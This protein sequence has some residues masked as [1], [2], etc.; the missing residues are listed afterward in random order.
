MADVY[1]RPLAQEVGGM[2]VSLDPALIAALKQV[3]GVTGASTYRAR[4][5]IVDGRRVAVA[6]IDAGFVSHYLKLE[7]LDAKPEE[8][9]PPTAAGDA[10]L[11]SEPFARRFHR[12]R[13]DTVSLVTPDGQRDFAIAGV[14]YDYTADRGVIMMDRAHFAHWWHDDTINSIALYTGPGVDATQVVET[15][16]HDY[17]GP[18]GLYVASNQ[19]LRDEILTIFDRT[20]SVTDIMQGLAAL[21]AFVGVLSALLA[22]LL[23]RTRE[24]GTLRAIGTTWQGLVKLIA[25][26]TAFMGLVAS[27]LAMGCG[28]ILSWILVY[29]INLRSFGWTIPLALQPV[30]FVEA[31]AIA[32]GASLLA[33]VIPAWRLKHLQTAQAMR[34]E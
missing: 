21:V 18:W 17:G 32:I 1:V 29:V 23:E 34:E 15:V 14:F 25:I 10:V 26:E 24:F 6:A 4:D 30:T 13:G 7:F 2:E 3:P 27:L 31:T 22:L 5:V 9:W 8:A 12:W 33:G 19:E 28:A 11:V 16:R 20:F